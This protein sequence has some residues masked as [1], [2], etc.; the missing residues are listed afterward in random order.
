MNKLYV[1]NAANMLILDNA[2]EES[3]LVFNSKQKQ[4]VHDA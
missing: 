4:S 3:K 2:S 1:I